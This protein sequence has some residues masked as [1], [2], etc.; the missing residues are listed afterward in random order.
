MAS[1]ASMTSNVESVLIGAG[2][3]R[4]A[5]TSYPG[6]AAR[7]VR[8]TAEMMLSVS[9]WFRVLT[10]SVVPTGATLPGPSRIRYGESPVASNGLRV[11]VMVK[12]SRFPQVPSLRARS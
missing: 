6:S 9:G 5:M 12:T 10:R 11:N 8:V 7:P 3:S 4:V 2:R 1:S